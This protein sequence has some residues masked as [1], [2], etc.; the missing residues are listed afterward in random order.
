MRTTLFS[1][2]QRPQIS[3]TSNTSDLFFGSDSEVDTDGFLKITNESVSPCECV[4]CIDAESCIVFNQCGHICCCEKCADDITECPLCRKIV[5]DMIK[6]NT[7]M[8]LKIKIS[9]SRLLIFIDV[10]M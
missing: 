2:K 6:I 8:A 7:L 10:S 5:G 1:Q 3:D 4:V 9:I